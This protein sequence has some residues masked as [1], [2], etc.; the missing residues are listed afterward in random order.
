M[1][2]LLLSYIVNYVALSY[3]GTYPKGAGGIVTNIVKPNSAVFC[4]TALKFLDFW[5]QKNH[6]KQLM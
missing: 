2:L 3:K 5:I 1:K 4:Q 6:F